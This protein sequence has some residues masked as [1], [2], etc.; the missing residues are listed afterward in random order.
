[1]LLA[2]RGTL[3]RKSAAYVKTHQ[4]LADALLPKN[5]EAI[6]IQIIE[7]FKLVRTSDWVYAHIP[8]GGNRSAREGARFKQ[9]GVV[10]GMP[11]LLIIFDSKAYFIE[12]KTAKGKTRPVQDDCHER[13]QRAGARVA[14]CRSLD[15]VRAA[16]KGWR[17]P[18]REV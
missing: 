5:E 15:D 9:L 17:V 2:P 13:L 4:D 6:Q 11:D 7:W 1:M 16:F 3:R 12:L 14:V 10:A 8:N 18:T